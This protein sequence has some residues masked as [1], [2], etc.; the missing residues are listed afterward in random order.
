MNTPF[1]DNIDKL[2]KVLIA[3]DD[4]TIRFMVQSILEAEG[5]KVIAVEDGKQ[6]ATQLEEKG[7]SEDLA[8]VVLDVM[9]PGMTGLDV[10]TRMK[11]NSNVS[12]IPVIMLT[13]ENKDSDI[14]AGYEQG[15]DYYIT[16]PFTRQQ[17]LFGIQTALGG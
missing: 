1:S 4:P 17:L 13:A 12:K 2:N 3:D 6:A 16:K 10:L 15:A 14:M 9:M 5:Y 11:L 8:F 7:F